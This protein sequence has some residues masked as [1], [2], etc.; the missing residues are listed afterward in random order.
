MTRVLMTAILIMGM[1]AACTPRSETAP[2]PRPVNADT[3]AA[4]DHSIS[5]I[6]DKSGSTIDYDT[7]MHIYQA[8]AGS[9]DPIPHT[10]QL[11]GQLIRKRNED[12]RIDQMIL[13]LAARIIGRSRYAIP[14][15]QDLF[16]SILK[17]DGRINEWV[18][19]FVAEAIDD[20]P[21]DLPQ[22]DRLVDA[23]QAKLKQLRSLDRS[24]QEYFGYHFLPPPKSDFIRAY[25]SGIGD[26]RI[27]QQE[28]ELYFVMI[29]TGLAET[30]IEAA[31]KFLQTQGAP[32][33]GE[34][35]PLLMQCLMR[36]RGELP[37]Q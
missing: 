2:V 19:S 32:G 21:Y 24:Q 18:I 12:P 22:G 13:I 37:F 9:A 26:R 11:L 27:R 3:G 4:A 7:L 34:R 23:M 8:M 33:S 25:I 1:Q 36:H 35:C 29:R 31:L 15:A 16:W 17:Q 6:L 5:S 10:D 20:S 30:Q 14:G 28:R